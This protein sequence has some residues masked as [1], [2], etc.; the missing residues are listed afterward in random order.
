MSLIRLKTKTIHEQ[1]SIK[2]PASKSISNRA[3]VINHLSADPAHI[4]NC[5]EAGDT[6]RLKSL[7]E[8]MNRNKGSDSITELDCGNAGTVARFITAVAA[9][10]PGKWL[11]TGDS[12]MQERPMKPLIEA[13][14]RLGAEIS[15]A[16]QN[17]FLPVIITGKN[18]PGGR[19]TIDGSVS[20]Q[21]LTALLL[22]SPMFENG[23]VLQWENE[24][25]SWPY[26]IMTL[27]MMAQCGINWS[28]KG[29]SI[30]VQPGRYRRCSLT[31]EPDWSAAAFWY[32]AVALQPRLRVS[33]KGLSMSGVH[34]RFQE[35]T[36]LP[37]GL[38]DFSC[39]EDLN[40]FPLQGDAVLPGLFRNFGVAT[41][42][43][44]NDLVL[45]NEGR[46]FQQLSELSFIACPD[47]AQ[48]S[49]TTC[50]ALG[51]PALFTGLE[52]LRVKETDRIQ[53]LITELKALG[54]DIVQE[55][56]TL[57]T[58]DHQ[59]GKITD[60]VSETWSDHRMAMSL[61]PLTLRYGQ[62]T[63]KDPEVVAKSY[64]GFWNELSKILD[65]SSVE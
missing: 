49:I 25:V 45:T 63:L 3:L 7:L 32:E 38:P 5:S 24:P 62:L 23:V 37:A 11:V 56:D 35:M 31:V 1:V 9:V 58:T 33:L 43:K 47:L 13:L 20:S 42:R 44:E 21:F 27:K 54:F 41:S 28:R 4:T 19:V 39:P 50:A 16:R 8:T 30:E 2:L 65:I 40:P 22:I 57:R 60:R 17:D 64:P 51:I 29:N 18:L 61:A 12:R 10:T 36:T 14:G 34:Q 52:T 55:G 46:R 6:R 53:A 15:P 48:P 26:L 59:P